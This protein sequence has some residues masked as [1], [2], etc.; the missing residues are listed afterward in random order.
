MN[1]KYNQ[2][3]VAFPFFTIRVTGENGG[4]WHFGSYQ[5]QSW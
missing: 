3:A 1:I 4:W 5:D 2:F